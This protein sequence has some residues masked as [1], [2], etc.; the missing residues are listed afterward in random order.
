MS[1]LYQKFKNCDEHGLN[2]ALIISCGFGNLEEVKYLLTS[3][4]LKIHADAET[5]I[6]SALELSCFRG[7]LDLIKYLLTSPELKK[8]ANL[9]AYEHD[10]IHT[11]FVNA[12]STNQLKVIEYFIFELNIERRPYMDEYFKYFPNPQVE[13]LFILR[14][15]DKSMPINEVAL[16]NK[17]LK[18]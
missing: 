6:D 15:L 9:H 10:Y 13:N 17:R 16:E 7:H 18:L 8:N 12:L 2:N 1:P 11:P 4:E 14:D 3:P 5:L